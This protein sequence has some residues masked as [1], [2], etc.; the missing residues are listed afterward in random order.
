MF[1]TFVYIEEDILTHPGTLQI[2]SKLGN[3]KVVP[4]KHYKDVFNQSGCFFILL[5]KQMKRFHTLRT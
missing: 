5:K 2:L 3:P 4:I 1:N